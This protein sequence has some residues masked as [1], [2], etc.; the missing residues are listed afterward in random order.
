[1]DAVV[2]TLASTFGP[3]WLRGRTL[4]HETWK[5]FLASAAALMVDYGVMVG[6][7]E[8]AHVHYL[9]SAAFGFSAGLVVNYLLSVTVVFSERR[10]A[11]RRIEFIG[12]VLIGLM[13][14][15]LNE[16]LMKLFVETVGLGYAVA[17]IPA[18]GVG[19]VFN[20]GLRRVALFT[21]PAEE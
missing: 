5:Y 13:G 4:F 16:G 7:T 20:F 9:I 1:M 15:A 11:D 2:A 19:F 12:F 8:L 6:L 10:I 3:L 18:T 17:K 21:A 14:L